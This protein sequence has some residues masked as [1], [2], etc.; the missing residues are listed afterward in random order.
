[1]K[2]DP[3]LMTKFVKIVEQFP[4]IY[5]PNSKAYKTQQAEISWDSIAAILKDELDVEWTGYKI[6]A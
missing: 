6:Y 2:D 5:D 3:E 4:E 1:M